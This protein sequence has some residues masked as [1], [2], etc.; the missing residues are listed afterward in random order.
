MK[1][2]FQ[3][4]ILSVIKSALFIKKKFI[5]YISYINVGNIEIRVVCG[6]RLHVSLKIAICTI[7][8]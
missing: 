2:N 7:I 3:G 6:K 1:Y 8:L 4:Q 5:L